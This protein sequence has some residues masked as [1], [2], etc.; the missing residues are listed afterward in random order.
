MVVTNQDEMEFESVYTIEGLF[1]D[2]WIMSEGQSP[3]SAANIN[4]DM[5]ATN[6]DPGKG[7]V[8]L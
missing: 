6:D 8:K 4:I 7:D 2:H 5:V 3:D 1:T